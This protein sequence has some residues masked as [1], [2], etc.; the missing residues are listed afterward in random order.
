MR[1]EYQFFAKEVITDGHCRCA[2]GE[3]IAAGWILTVNTC[4]LYIPEAATPDYACIC[5]ETGPN[6]I[7]IRSRGKDVGRRGMSTLNPFYVGEYQRIHGCAPNAD[8]G[9]T[10]SLSI[11]G[12]LMPL[13]DWRQ[14]AG[15]VI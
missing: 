6:E 13:W 10:I 2:Y 8:I 1:F 9:D 11:V 14:S 12:Y 7:M 4:Y 5:V 15:K 3:R